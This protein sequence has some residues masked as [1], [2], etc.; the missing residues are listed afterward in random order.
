MEF[1][2]IQPGAFSKLTCLRTM[3]VIITFIDTRFMLWMLMFNMKR[4]PAQ[5]TWAKFSPFFSF[6]CKISINNQRIKRNTEIRNIPSG[7]LYTLTFCNRLKMFSF[8]FL[9][10]FCLCS[11]TSRM[12][13]NWCIYR[14]M[15]SKGFHPHSN[16]CELTIIESNFSNESKTVECR[17]K[18]L[19]WKRFLFF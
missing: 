13:Q 15:S 14:R 16:H 2:S 4:S 17:S 1:K 7:C 8:A 6:E 19:D 12:L 11:V 9:F 5:V 10:S 3:Y 18:Y